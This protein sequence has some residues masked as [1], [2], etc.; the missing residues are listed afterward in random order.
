MRIAAARLLVLRT[1]EDRSIS[2]TFIHNIPTTWREAMFQLLDEAVRGVGDPRFA[3][4]LK[5]GGA[6]RPDEPPSTRSIYRW[7]L[8]LEAADYDWRKLDPWRNADEVVDMPCAPQG[9]LV[10]RLLRRQFQAR[11]HHRL[12]RH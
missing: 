9:K 4:A 5:L 10:D 8:T 12:S 7:Q 11:S 2:D 3:E 1:I 6:Y